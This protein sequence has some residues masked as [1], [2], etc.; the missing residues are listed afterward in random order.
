MEPARLLDGSIVKDDDFPIGFGLRGGTDSDGERIAHHA[1]A[2]MGARSVLLLYPDREVAVSVLSNAPWVSEI[3]QTAITL[4]APFRQRLRKRGAHPCPVGATRYDGLFK[5][6]P[7]SGSAHF[8]LEEGICVGTI[9]IDGDIAGWFNGP[10][11]KDAASLK[12]IGL[13]AGGGLAR[14]ALVIPFGAFDLNPEAAGYVARFNSTQ[15][16]QISFR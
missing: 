13:Q 16:L 9:T 10:P 1:G 3:E 14:A 4:S 6:R 15:S 5:D 2:A 7:L 11:Q 12:I 8:A